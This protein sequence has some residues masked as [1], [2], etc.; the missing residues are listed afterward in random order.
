MRPRKLI[1]SAF[2]S[3][4]G[5]TEIDFTGQKSGLFLITGDTGAGKTTIFDAIT[6][7][8]YNETSG[9]ERNGAMMRS[10]YAS[11][12]LQT[13]V[14]FEFEYAGEVYHIKRNPEYKIT[15]ELKNGKRR[16]QKVPSGVELILPDGSVFPEKQKGTDARIEEIIG[17]TVEQFTQIVMIAQ[18][19]FLKLLYT[20]S[21]DR[22]VIFSKLFRTGDYWRIQ[23]NLRRRSLEMDDAIAENERA[24]A[25]EQAR[26][27]LPREELAGLPLAEAVDQIRRWEKELAAEQNEKRKELDGLQRKLAQA[28]EVNSLFVTL[29]K[30]EEKK[31]RLEAET[32]RE[33]ERQ[34]RIAAALQAD[35]VFIEEQRLEEKEKEREKSLAAL[36]EL[37][38]WIEREGIEYQKRE[39]M[40]KEQE[41]ENR[42]ATELAGKEIHRI[43]E[44]LP[45][46]EKLSR[47]ILEE[48]Q[49]KDKFENARQEYEGALKNKAVQL[50]LRME[51]VTRA[52]VR[53]R[54]A[55]TAWEA[56]SGAAREA[57]L[58][59]EQVYQ[60]FLAEQA[61]ILAQDL[62]E[63]MPCPV[64]GSLSHPAPAVL[65]D[66]AVGEEDVKRAKQRREAAEEKREAARVTFEEWRQ[67]ET[68]GKILLEQE[69]ERFKE[70]A[71]ELCGISEEELR[72]YA[73]VS[74]TG[75]TRG[76]GVSGAKGMMTALLN[77]DGRETAK[78]QTKEMESGSGEPDRIT[79][80]G[81]E[82][83]R[84]DWQ[85]RI[86]ETVKIRE[87]LSYPTEAEARA[88]L[89]RLCSEEEARRSAYLDR[90]QE[91]ERLRV[92]LDT[93]K[94]QRLQEEEAE[95]QLEK[96]CEKLRRA[97]EKAME[98]AGFASGEEYRAS[99]LSERTRKS[100]ER[101]S[102][103]Y[104]KACQENAGQLGA[105]K[106]A[107]AGKEETSTLELKAAIAGA[108]AERKRLEKERLSMHT[109]YETDSAVLEH[110]SSYL[111]K[112]QRLAEEDWVVKS[113][114]RTANGRLGGSAKIDFETYIQ[115]QYFRQI[116]HEANKRLLTMSGHQ[117]MLKLKEAAST[118]HKSN[119]GLDLAV[120]SLVTDSERD[121]K[122]L[123]GGESFLAALAMALGLSD[124]A[125]RKA[126]AVHLDMMFIDEGFG[127]LD[128]Q[129]RKQAIEV[130]DS[131]SGGERLVGIISHVTELKEQID[132]RLLVTRTEKGSRAVW[133]EDER[134]L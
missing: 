65:S 116:I 10:Q 43:E 34:E 17:L 131:L 67:K 60:R 9:G 7:A 111:E 11:P 44:S 104:V 42:T 48:E 23:E 41:E 86:R 92:E 69:K 118:G 90:Q 61:G 128:A 74:G 83:R 33:Q 85:E 21:A 77:A 76:Q 123:S 19:D 80:A 3:Y 81:V 2:G 72:D 126:G 122:T 112:K 53:H 132:H 50:L 12:T 125:I 58:H 82:E 24:A 66:E 105:L 27:I 64:C 98:K 26:I 102:E 22:K 127:S 70:A 88:V 84:R 91:N 31:K 95:K 47:A 59:H 130:L 79:R 115:R 30:L 55:Y 134:D 28:E 93:K 117:F 96:D 14:E 56:A 124:I 99:R 108:E 75:E 68:E 57:V 6:Y 13:Y 78:K 73:G 119:E 49:A 4:A 18:G 97:F 29:R 5:R 45:E 63:D 1:L 15:K 113:L 107:T 16:E 103:S 109:A 100:L 114:Y 94:G 106:K 46:Y 20:K 120:Y 40:L 51:E 121:I 129:S 35:K 38:S 39:K 52:G 89:E 25:Q 8:L 101:E 133:E 71:G 32:D 37:Y 62:K 54:E 36:S 110:C 87:G